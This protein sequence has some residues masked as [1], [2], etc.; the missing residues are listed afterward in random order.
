MSVHF[1]EIESPIGRLLLV[2]DAH[3]LRGIEYEQPRHP[4]ARGAD[5]R[6]GE[7]GVLRAAR[8]QLGQYFRGERRRFE[9]PLAPQGTPFQHR[10]WQALKGIEYGLTCS[11]AD[12]ARQLGE[13]QATRAVGAANG[14]NPLSIVVPCHRVIGADGNL[15]GYGGGLERKRFLLALEGALPVAD[16]FGG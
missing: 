13:A 10:V 5:W 6:E 12:I 1:L 16:L 14:R 3:G 4:L 8:A 7:T 15:T 2:A 9:L 11:Y